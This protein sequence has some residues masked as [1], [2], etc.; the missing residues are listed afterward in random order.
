M[1][2]STQDY[3]TPP[4]HHVAVIMDGNGRWAKERGLPRLA[5]HRAGT[6]N[7]RSVARCLAERGVE[8]LTLYAFST[9]NWGRPDAEVRGLIEILEGV[10]EQEAKILHGDNVRLNHLGR[11]D[12][13]SWKLQRSI[14][15]AVHLT[16]S[17]TGLTLSVAFDY[18]GRDEILTAVR[19]LLKDGIP[20]DEVDGA[21]FNRYLYTS[22]L[23]DPDLIIRTAGEMRLSNFLLWQSAYSEYYSAPVLWP[24]FNEHQVVIALESYCRRHRR[25]GGLHSGDQQ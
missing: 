5:G 7:I 10:I 9:E 20:S 17:N 4:P 21:V 16:Q 13:L 19:S 25:F 6:E 15:D 1:S 2:F 18:G 11:L 3:L 24:D 8:F 12:R 22:C 23:P 14:K